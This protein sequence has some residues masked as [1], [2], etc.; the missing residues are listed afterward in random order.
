[1]NETLTAQ[2]ET[3][4]R[5]PIISTIMLNDPSLSTVALLHDIRQSADLLDLRSGVI[6]GLAATPK[7]L[8]SLLLWDDQGLTNFEAWTKSPAYYP[9]SRELEILHNHCHD[10]ARSLPDRFVLI[11]LGCG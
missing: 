10:I 4:Y 7:R 1:M 8:P 3:V 11:E 6:A 5:A 9:K 2:R